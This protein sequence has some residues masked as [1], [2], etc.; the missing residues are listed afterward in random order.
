MQE[1]ESQESVV[2]VD[3][4][5]QALG[6]AEK[7]YAHEQALLHRAFSVFLFRTNPKTGDLELLL[8]K[9]SAQKYH[10]GGLWTNT[11][12][13]HPRQGEGIHEAAIRR[14]QEE[15]NLRLEAKNLEAM[16]FF[17]YQAELANHLFEHEL[18]HV[19]VG[20]LESEQ[21][22][23]APNPLE[24]ES[25]K[26]MHWEDLKMDLI[27]APNRYTPWLGLAMEHLEKVWQ[28]MPQKKG[29]LIQC[30]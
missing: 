4:K 26:W 10:C 7:L 21:V 23:S 12:C 9:R 11:C 28:K 22:L 17:V 15:L 2:L 16:G 13:S 1:P 14:V 8:Q 24:I 18:D 20:K 19:L 30:G 29:E 3:E 5:D 25:L 6:L 27:K